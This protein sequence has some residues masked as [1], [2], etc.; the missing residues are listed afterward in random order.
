MD[1]RRFLKA[2]S[3]VGIAGA[4][5]CQDHLEDQKGSEPTPTEERTDTPEPNTGQDTADTEQES[6]ETE[7]SVYRVAP[8]GEDSNLGSTEEPIA[9]I[10]EA[11]QR[12]TPGDTI[13]VASGTYREEHAPGIPLQTIRDGKPNAPITITGPQD[14]ILRPSLRIKH[15]HIRLEGITIEAL[16]NPEK[17]DDPSSYAGYAIEIRPPKDSDD[18]LE[19]IVCAPAGVGYSAYALIRVVR[20]KD[21]EIGPLRVTGLAGASWILP[22]ES[23]RHAGEIIYLGSPPGMVFD[24]YGPDVDYPW[25][26]EIDETRNVHIHHIDNSGSHPHSELVDAKLG[27][28]NILVEYCTDAG[29]SQNTERYPPCSIGLKGYNSTVRWCELKNGE[30]DGIRIYAGGRR[31]GQELDEPTIP[32]EKIGK[33]NAI[34]GNRIQGFGNSP[35]MLKTGH[36]DPDQRQFELVTPED[37]EYL[38]GND[39]GNLYTQRIDYTDIEKLDFDLTQTC[40]DELPEGDGIGHTGG[41]SPWE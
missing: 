34:Y 9:T 12:A 11:L 2:T 29:G 33:G 38:C 24:S 21:L 40:S 19:D 30:G 23:D 6:E 25:A 17:R 28:R 22:D 27:T 26:G 36:P 10:H 32:S 20:T 18:Y 8:D 5:G 7:S 15:S 13:D 1:R 39:A 14:A 31:L 41:D 3:T 35:V 4:A 16:L 37:Q